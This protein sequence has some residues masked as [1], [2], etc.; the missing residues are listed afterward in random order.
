MMII[1]SYGIENIVGKRENAGYQHFLP[2]SLS[3]SV[4]K[5]HIS[6]GCSN[7][8]LSGKGLKGRKDINKDKK[9]WLTVF[10]ALATMFL[11]ASFLNTVHANHLTNDKF[12][13][14][15]K[16]KADNKINKSYTQKF[17]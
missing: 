16:L 1:I 3:N 17:F 2:F 15:S 5:R 13:D 11:K 7:K 10:S 9:Y 14:W 6:K 4:L 8:E 12:F